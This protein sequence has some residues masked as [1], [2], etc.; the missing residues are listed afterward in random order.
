MEGK[1]FRESFVVLPRRKCLLGEG[2]LQAYFIYLYICIV[3]LYV[4][5]IYKMIY[6]YNIYDTYTYRPVIIYIMYNID[7]YYRYMS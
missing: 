2:C 5:Y 4:F 6:V 1:A 3:Y 7:L